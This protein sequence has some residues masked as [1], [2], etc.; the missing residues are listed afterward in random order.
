[1]LSKMAES[2]GAHQLSNFYSKTQREQ[3]KRWGVES[4]GFVSGPR[5]KSKCIMGLSKLCEIKAH[6]RA[7][8]GNCL[9]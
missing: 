7:N 2:V 8:R 5:N 9:G 4:A 6:D 1:M 3:T